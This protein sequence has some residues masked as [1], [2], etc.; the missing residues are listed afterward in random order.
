MPQGNPRRLG[1][2]GI[3]CHIAAESPF[4]ADFSLI[5]PQ[6][7]TP[8]P[9][10]RIDSHN[11]GDKAALS[12]QS[13]GGQMEPR[14]RQCAGFQP[15]RPGSPPD[16]KIRIPPTCIPAADCIRIQEYHLFQRMNTPRR[17]REAPNIAEH[18]NELILRSG[19][20]LFRPAVGIRVNRVVHAQP[21]RR[22]VH[23]FHEG[24]RGGG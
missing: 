23:P 2:P 7:E 14:F 18:Q 6:P 1:Q 22:A 24:P 5:R 20:R 4:E 16:K 12:P 17:I 19:H 9:V 13:R 3:P 15:V 8:E 11:Q 10:P 21:G